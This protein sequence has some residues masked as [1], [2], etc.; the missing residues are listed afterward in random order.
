[1]SNNELWNLLKYFFPFYRIFY[2]HFYEKSRTWSTQWSARIFYNTS[3]GKSRTSDSIYMIR[4]EK[5]KW[6]GFS[7]FCVIFLYGKAS[8][9]QKNFPFNYTN[10]HWMSKELFHV[11]RSW[12]ELVLIEGSAFWRSKGHHYSFASTWSC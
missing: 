4:I 3:D 11:L 5:D 6:R 7:L 12:S 9:L 8:K 2:K 10:C 1:M